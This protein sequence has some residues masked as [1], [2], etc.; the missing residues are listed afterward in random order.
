MS[1][2][3]NAA[4]ALWARFAE[5]ARRAG[6]SSLEKAAL[7]LWF[8]RGY[9]QTSAPT[10]EFLQRFAPSV[11]RPPAVVWQVF[12]SQNWTKGD[13]ENVAAALKG[14]GHF[15]LLSP[16]VQQKFGQAA[17]QLLSQ[18]GIATRKPS[19]APSQSPQRGS[20]A[21]PLLIGVGLLG[22]IL[23]SRRKG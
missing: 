7:D 10:K 8:R 21:V 18:K 12:T 17:F 15:G 22:L 4:T 13:L 23:F 9:A 14:S 1:K 5:A 2:T 20:A 11:S 3:N 16:S 6:P 19:A